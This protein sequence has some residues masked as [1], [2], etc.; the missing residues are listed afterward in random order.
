MA[1]SVIQVVVSAAEV[2]EVLVED[3][4][5]MDE[6]EIVVEEADDGARTMALQPTSMLTMSRRSHPSLDR[7]CTI[8]VDLGYCFPDLKAINLNS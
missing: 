8:V 4:V 2:D 5:A 1:G 6:A 7:C 3:L